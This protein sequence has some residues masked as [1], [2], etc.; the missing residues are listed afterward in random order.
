MKIPLDHDFRSD[1]VTQPSVAMKAYMATQPLG[2]DVFEEC[3]TT[4][5]LQE[6]I[7]EYLGKEAALLFPTGS[8]ANLTALICHAQ[9]GTILFAGQN[10]HIKLYEKGSYARFAGLNLFEV[11]DRD[12]QLDLKALKNVWPHGGLYDSVPGIVAVE[13]THNKNGG[14]IY[15]ETELEDLSAWVGSRESSLKKNIPIHMDGARLAHVAV[16]E[17]RPATDWTRHVDTVMM[18]LSK[19]LGCPV[20]SLLAGSESFIRKARDVRKVLG[21]GMR[22]CGILAAAGLYA[23]DHNLPLLATDHE[24]CKRFYEGV[25]DLDWLDVKEPQTNILIATLESSNAEKLVNDMKKAG[26]YFIALSANTI[27]LVFHLNL[28][29]TAVDDAITAFR[30]WEP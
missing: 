4:I 30:Q 2:D 29:G 24:R 1:T 25:N 10:S 13:N 11:P 8:M 17:N 21:G 9:P 14:L 7:A 16:A 5:T 27:R 22:Q 12:G 18:C 20:G 6:R 28:N 3:P 19:G 15:P 26:I 23:L